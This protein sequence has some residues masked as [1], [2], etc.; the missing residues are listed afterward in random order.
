MRKSA[1]GLLTYVL[2]GM[3]FYCWICP[4]EGDELPGTNS[5]GVVTWIDS[6]YFTMVTL[7]TVGYGDFHPAANDTV[8]ELF[9]CLFVLFGILFVSIGLSFFVGNIL[10]QQE[11]LIASVLDNDDGAELPG[12]CGLSLRDW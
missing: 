8:S 9:T 4:L 6:L 7:T 5:T 2:T 11:K 3:V 12:K 1:L 10:D